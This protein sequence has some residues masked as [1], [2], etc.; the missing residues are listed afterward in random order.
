MLFFFFR[1]FSASVQE[2]L[3]RGEGDIADLIAINIKRG[4]DRGLPSY[5]AF[6]NSRLCNLTRVRS[7]DDF[8]TVAGIPEAFVEKMRSQYESFQDV[9]LFSAGANLVIFN[10]RKVE[11]FIAFKAVYS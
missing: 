11:Q 2:N 9:D 6:R 5:A 10:S 7:F 3:A 4:H 1:E 8:V